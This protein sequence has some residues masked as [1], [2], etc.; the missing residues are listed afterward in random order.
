MLTTYEDAIRSMNNLWWFTRPTEVVLDE[1]IVR[2][3]VLCRRTAPIK[4]YR[5]VW[6]KKP[7][8]K[9]DNVGKVKYIGMHFVGSKKDFKNL[10][11]LERLYQAN[12]QNIWKYPYPDFKKDRYTFEVIANPADIN[13]KMTLEDNIGWPFDKEIMLKKGSRVKIVDITRWGR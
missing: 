4:L 3:E 9:K 7:I 6:S 8:T 2:L 10:L 12:I 13:I 11:M 5:T 1:I